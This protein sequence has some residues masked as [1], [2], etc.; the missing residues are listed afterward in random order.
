[1]S[2][3]QDPIPKGWK[4]WRG[5]VPSEL[6]DMAKDVRDH[7]G[8]YE[9]GKLAQVS[10]YAGQPVATFK[11]RHTWTYKDGKLVTGICIPGV[12]LLVPVA[13]YTVAGVAPDTA[14]DLSRPDPELATWD[15]SAAPQS[16]LGVMWQGLK[17]LVGRP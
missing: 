15:A 14:V 10:I 8:L 2:C 13:P 12:S 17:N 11:S 16:V 5:A 6:A 9:Y 4:V 3:Y 1:V 7:I